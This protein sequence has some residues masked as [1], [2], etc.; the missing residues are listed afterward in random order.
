MFMCDIEPDEC[1]TGNYTCNE[2][3]ECV[4]INGNFSC[5]CRPGFAR[6]NSTDSA[7]NTLCTDID[8]CSMT[9]DKCS[10]NAICLNNNG[11]YSC[12]CRMGYIGD[13]FTCQECA[14]NG[15]CGGPNMDDC[16]T[17]NKT[18]DETSQ[19]VNINSTLRCQCRPGYILNNNDVDSGNGALC[20]DIDECLMNMDNCSFNAVC[21]N[22]NGSYTCTC[23]MGFSGDGFTCHDINECISNNTC[24]ANAECT[25]FEG[26]HSCQCI[27]GYTGNGKVCT[28]IDECT[29]GINNCS[30]NATCENVQGSYR[31][32]C[33][34]G[35]SGDG[36]TCNDINECTSKEH[37]CSINAYCRNNVGMYTCACK[38]GYVGD[39]FTC[40]DINE[41]NHAG[42]NNCANNSL[43]INTDGSYQCRCN[44]GYS[45]NPL[46][47]CN[48]I[49]ECSINQDYCNNNAQCI[50]TP[51][52]FT[53]RCNQGYY[54]NGINCVPVITCNG[55]NNCG[56]KATCM[57]SQNQ[58][59]CSCKTGFYSKSASVETQLQTD[60]H[61]QLGI[62]FQGSLFIAG[63]F[64]SD[65][66]NPN[67][68][69]F[70][71]LQ[72]QATSSLTS[73][74]NSSSVTKDNFERVVISGFKSGSIIISYYPI[75]KQS[76]DINPSQIANIISSSQVTIEGKPIQNVTV[77]YFDECANPADNICNTTTNQNCFNLPGNY[78]CQCKTGYT[79]SNCDDIDEC[80]ANQPC[81]RNTRCINSIGSYTCT[82]IP[83]YQGNPYSSL[84]CTIE[85][86]GDYC[87]NGGTCFYQNNQRQCNCS[88]EYTG[89]RCTVQVAT[90]LSSGAI[91]G[92]SIGSV[93]AV[94]LIII[95]GI[96]FYLQSPMRKRSRSV[97][98]AIAPDTT[99]NQ[100]IRPSPGQVDY[101]L[102]YRSNSPSTEARRQ[103]FDNKAYETSA[104][105]PNVI[106]SAKVPT[107]ENIFVQQPY[108]LEDNHNMVNVNSS[109]RQENDALIRK[110]NRPILEPLPKLGG[111]PSDSSHF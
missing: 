82:C 86:N 102:E 76:T 3:E 45:G 10:Y 27:A 36:I 92:I 65:L 22:N 85:C 8:E 83:G 53:C 59:Y 51:G 38:D 39:G 62:T 2:S 28:E 73:I 32:H 80:S 33:V 89:I 98:H 94:L 79:G 11:S 40:R 101:E 78:K 6:N 20:R 99:Q 67:S 107:Q 57:I 95:I 74:L 91:L 9:L 15:T 106:I 18:C 12:V 29:S 23:K 16:N 52:S 17:G 77:S 43:C 97:G 14:T 84:G 35:F 100:L 110:S 71:Q 50:N 68:S 44:P 48:D 47:A 26:S 49:N 72:Q 109:V 93:S 69:A 63:T 70:Q 104:D 34:E 24:D 41:C 60:S 25:N 90:G 61:C 7:N 108:T 81:S 103:G 42:L 111:Q 96:I 75:F 54:G 55:N 66:N 31:C 13:G 88:G 30:M 56:N 105:S 19:C 5:Q 4:N 87:L 37:N 1:S 21:L 64:T 46:K 58:Y